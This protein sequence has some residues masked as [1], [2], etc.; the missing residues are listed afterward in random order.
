[1]TRV[2]II[3]TFI[4]ALVGQ[5][6]AYAT[7]ACDMDDMS[8]MTHEGMMKEM[9]H[10][11]DNEHAHHMMV[12]QMASDT[13]AHGD[14]CMTQCECPPSQCHTTVFLHDELINTARIQT[15]SILGYALNNFTSTTLNSLY[16]PPI[17][18]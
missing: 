18:A 3:I 12:E 17:M 4:V 6:F 16:R 11:T 5:S 13:S 9:H 15:K 7:M 10:A 14:C 8:M 1:M 2:Y